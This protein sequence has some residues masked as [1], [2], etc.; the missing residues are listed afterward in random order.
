MGRIFIAKYGLIVRQILD[1]TGGVIMELYSQPG[2]SE[3]VFWGDIIAFLFFVIL[4]IVFMGVMTTKKFV[5]LQK[6]AEVFKT[7]QKMNMETNVGVSTDFQ[8]N[9]SASKQNIRDL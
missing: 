2:E 9:M 5:R 6:S 7:I 3:P 8:K 4:Q 1:E